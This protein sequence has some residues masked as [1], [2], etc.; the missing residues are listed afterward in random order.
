MG[1]NYGDIDNDG[2]LDVY[3]GTGAPSFTAIVPN[4]MYRNNKGKKLQD[5]TT[6]AGVGHIQKGHGVGFG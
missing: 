2:F 6:T 1:S 5:V 3:F 4:K